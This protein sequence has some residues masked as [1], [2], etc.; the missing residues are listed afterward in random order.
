MLNKGENMYCYKDEHI[1]RN[2]FRLYDKDMERTKGLIHIGTVR[3]KAFKFIPRS[4]DEFESANQA[5]DHVLGKFLTDQIRYKEGFHD[6]DA[7][8]ATEVSEDPYEYPSSM[9]HINY[10]IDCYSMNNGSYCPFEPRTDLSPAEIDRF[11]SEDTITRRKNLGELVTSLFQKI[12][13]HS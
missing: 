1:G 12:F 8:H 4:I 3:V 9:I 10:D 13:K 6:V 2:F 7:Y 11:G 5:H